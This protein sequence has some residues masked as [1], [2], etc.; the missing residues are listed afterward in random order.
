MSDNILENLK[1]Q[2]LPNARAVSNVLV[3]LWVTA[4]LKCGYWPP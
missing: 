4:G 1:G 3:K 2:V